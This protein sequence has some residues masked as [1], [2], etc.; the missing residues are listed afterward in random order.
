[1]F[2]SIY[3]KLHSRVEATLWI[4]NNISNDKII[5]G[6]HWDDAL[7]LRG[8]TGSATEKTYAIELLP[9]FGPD[10]PEKWNEMDVLLEKGDYLILSSNRGWGSIPTAPERY[11]RMTKFYKDLFEEKLEFK[12]IAEFTSYPSLAYLGI[13][14]TFPD[15]WA[16]EA[17]TVY[18]HPK[19]IIFQKK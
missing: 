18:D 5:L 17:F 8:V 10:I 3:T 12:K 4:Q 1:M 14:L 11:P 13:P 16:D 6:E 19:V 9:V 2:F 15:Q 7:P